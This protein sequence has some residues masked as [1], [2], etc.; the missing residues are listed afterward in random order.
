MPL[1]HPQ[2]PKP[3]AHGH[4]SLVMSISAGDPNLNCLYCCKRVWISPEPS[5]RHAQPA[6]LPPICSISSLA[7]SSWSS[8]CAGEGGLRRESLGSAAEPLL[9]SCKPLF[10][11]RMPKRTSSGPCCFCAHRPAWASAAHSADCDEPGHE[12]VR[13]DRR[14]RWS[15]PSDHRARNPGRAA[16]ITK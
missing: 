6:L 10:L 1:W 8:P 9:P 15:N 3:V 12:R 2:Y 4:E 5:H 7:S 16:T 13:G 11:V 14:S